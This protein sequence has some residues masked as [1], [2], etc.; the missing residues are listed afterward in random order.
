MA[1]GSGRFVCQGCGR[2]VVRDDL[3]CPTC[4]DDRTSAAAAALMTGGGVGGAIAIDGWRKRVRRFL[5]RR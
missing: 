1:L 5:G 4:A 3:R 2:R